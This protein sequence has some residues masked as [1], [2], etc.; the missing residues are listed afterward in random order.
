[1][2]YSS[3]DLLN[4]VFAFCVLWLTIFLSWTLYYVA[5][6]LRDA[7]RM[8]EELRQRLQ[9]VDQFVKLVSEKLEHTTS[10]L[11]LMVETMGRLMSYFEARGETKRKRSSRE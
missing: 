5:L 1:M 7:Y 3:Q 2:L 10:Y 4:I 9:T 6:I 11:G 8:T